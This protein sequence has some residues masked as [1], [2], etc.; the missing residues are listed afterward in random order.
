MT[1]LHYRTGWL[2]HVPSRVL[3]ALILGHIPIEQQ[4][5]WL[6]GQEI[7]YRDPKAA[8]K[9][10]NVEQL[11]R[12]INAYPEN[13]PD[14][15]VEAYFREYR[16]G[17]SPTLHLFVFPSAALETFD[18]AQANRRAAL[19]LPR[20]NEE[21][22][23]ETS[24]EGMSP[25]LQNLALEP[26]AQ[27]DGWPD[28]LH[29]GYH[30]QSRLDYIDVDGAAAQV[31]E[32]LYGHIW[33]D[34]TRAF[35]ALH[36]H[37]ARLESTLVW[38]LSQVLAA[39]LRLV[40][41]DKELKRQLEFL[42]TASLRRARLVDPSPERTRFRSITLSD[43]ED[44]ARRE[45]RG[46]GYREWEDDYPEMA[47]ARYYAQFVKD[48]ELSLSIGVRRGSL[49]L[50]GAVAASELQF[51]ARDTGAQVV[52]MWL[53]RE[54]DYLS[55]PPAALDYDRLRAHPL[56]E[57]FPE[58]LRGLVLTLVR[59][60]ATIKERQDRLFH[61]WPLPLPVADLALAAARADAQELLGQASR[62]GG[63]APWF[64]TM[65]RVDCPVGDCAAMSEYLVCPACGRALFT[66]ALSDQEERVLMCAN[67]RCR[68]RW[69]GAFPLQTQ[70]EEE[71]PIQLEWDGQIGQRLALFV[72]K[73]LAFLL[74]ELLQDEEDVYRFRAQKESLWVRDGRLVH[75][76]IGVAYAKG[77]ASRT[78]IDSGGGAVVQ[79]S[80]IVYGDFIG[81]DQVQMSQAAAEEEDGP[82]ADRDKAA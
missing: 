44:L 68:E 61:A 2:L 18:L 11:I 59:A 12:L 46:W 70:C 47:S 34:L 8:L 14:D 62:A 13:V 15:L 22:A 3:Q 50:T 37:P 66:L 76:G 54:Q 35:V 16:H 36:L 57:A 31:Y 58:D 71:H 80:L 6:E 55:R 52:E 41:V 20:A 77:K 27:P 29:A 30:V 82:P 51:W 75:Q 60:L 81:R 72:S 48:R 7:G 19:A 42:R 73:E 65:V 79:G 32:L 21:L 78:E 33:L 49:T 38:L 24:E 53:A 56:L 67:A 9:R 23:R 4:G 39:P 26:F 28:G 10:L 17:R 63:P 45:Y 69:A 64:H 40:R 74:Q 5:R 1:E 25:R 43:D